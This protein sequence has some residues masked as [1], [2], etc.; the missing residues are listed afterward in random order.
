[1]SD[2]MTN[3]PAA[4]AAPDA[5]DASAA[6]ST[7]PTEQSPPAAPAPQ[8]EGATNAPAADGT[9][10]T[11]AQP[12]GD[13]P[14][15]GPPEAYE[16]R[17]PDGREY[18]PET[19][20]AYGT[21]ARELG[22][23]QD[24]AARILDHMA[25][26]IESQQAQAVQ[27]IRGEWLKTTQ[28]DPEIGG[29]NLE[30]TVLSARAALD[31]YGSPELKTLLDQSGLGDHPEVVRFFARVGASTSDDTV[32]TGAAPRAQSSFYPNSNHAR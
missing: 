21:V 19:L 22:L 31:R 13:K 30:A 1:M 24:Q 12:D 4:P 9:L 15:D 3:A 29:R 17:A 2:E 18:S 8:S 26:V 28:A 16:F 27:A 32:L 25:P 10:L 11:Q 20:A 14:A 5:P 7:P 23:T 6:P